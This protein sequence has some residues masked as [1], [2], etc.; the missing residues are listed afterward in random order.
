MRK[1]EVHRSP[2]LPDPGA[3]EAKETK[4]DEALKMQINEVLGHYS[5]TEEEEEEGEFNG[6][7]LAFIED[8]KFEAVSMMLD[9]ASGINVV[10]E[11]CDDILSAIAR[12]AKQGALSPGDIFEH[13]DEFINVMAIHDEVWSEPVLDLC[14]Y[15]DSDA[16]AQVAMAEKVTQM[17]YDEMFSVLQC[18]PASYMSIVL[19]RENIL[20]ELEAF[21]ASKDIHGEYLYAGVVAMIFE[22]MSV[23]Q[24]KLLLPILIDGAMNAQRSSAVLDSVRPGIK[25]S[26]REVKQ[27]ITEAYAARYVDHED[28]ERVGAQLIEGFALTVA[29]RREKRVRKPLELVVEGILETPMAKKDIFEGSMDVLPL[30]NKQAWISVHSPDVAR[31][32]V[33]GAKSVLEGKQISQLRK[34]FV[35]HIGAV[36]PN[37]DHFSYYADEVIDAVKALAKQNQKFRESEAWGGLSDLLGEQDGVELRYMK[38][39]KSDLRLGNK[40]GDCTAQGSINYENSLSWYVNPAYQLMMMKEGG[41]FMGKIGMTIAMRGDTKVIFI[42]ALEFHPQATDGKPYRDRA[43]KAFER[44]IEHIRVMGDGENAQVIALMRS[45]SFSANDE[46][47]DMGSTSIQGVEEA[48]V[49]DEETDTLQKVEVVKLKLELP[50]SVM[51]LLSAHDGKIWYQMFEHKMNDNAFSDFTKSSKDLI[52]GRLT[53]LETSVINP[54]Q[55][56]NTEVSVAM[57]ERDF[58]TA[59]K[60]IMKDDHWAAL[61]GEFFG[62]PLDVGRVSP[63]MLAKKL[64]TM[65]S[66][67][68]ETVESLSAQV[69][70]DASVLVQL[71]AST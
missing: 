17:P 54:V 51:E 38:R 55:I 1:G 46:L 71:Q 44:A 19:R 3:P 68:G 11:Y 64:E 48:Q 34:L 37:E 41:K 15:I 22:K 60:L 62:I 63:K 32:I 10:A 28:I 47:K 39:E 56:A 16:D 18:L 13:L 61:V 26:E 35:K 2:G 6:K 50:E 7:V 57:N 36:K 59:S 49:T 8:R 20:D 43:M 12:S 31:Q 23:A 30:E 53:E 24:Q 70:L 25:I 52:D 69:A 65:Y 58:L 21:S 40:T 66:S 5:L 9:Y 29:D 42:D 14:E 33:S 4:V 45:N 67:D 27:M